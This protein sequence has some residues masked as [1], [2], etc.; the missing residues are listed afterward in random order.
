MTERSFLFVPGNRPDRFVKAG[1][2]GAHAIIL[3][4]EDAVGEDQKLEARASVRRWLEEGGTGWL[5]LN[6]TESRWHEEDLAL[7]SL[8]GLRGLMLPKAEEPREVR[9]LAERMLPGMPLIPLVETGLGMWNAHRIA[10][11][12]G[13]QR[14]AFG[15][16]DYQHDMGIHGDDEELIHARAMLVLAARVA[17]SLPPVDG[18]TT[19]IQDQGLLQ[20]D[21]T[22]ARRFGFSGKLCIHPGQ[23]EIVNAGFLPT[24]R[25]LELARKVVAAAES[26]GQDAVQLE[27]KLIDLPVIARARAMLKEKA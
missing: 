9:R 6:G 27:G 19:A 5:R 22:R 7:I 25:E 13:V 15:S 12:P 1:R 10:G 11:V 14:L 8:P 17:G 26:A 20:R 18:V 2:S 4:L 23:V 16:V 3:D 24:G 21:V